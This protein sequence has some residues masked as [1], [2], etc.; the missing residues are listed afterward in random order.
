M[1]GTNDWNSTTYD[2]AHSFVYEYGG[3]LLSLLEPTP[4]DRILDLGCGTGHLTRQVADSGA[5][6]V[7]LDSARPMV[8]SAR[9]TYP[10]LSFVHGDARSLPFENAFDAVLSNA[11][12]HWISPLD[13]ALDAVAAALR[14]GGRFVAELGASGNVESIVTALESALQAAG[15]ESTNPWYFPTIG[16]GATRLER[17]G[18]EVRYARV[19]DRP[20]TLD[21]RDGLRNWIE[22]FADSFLA[23]VPVE[24]T[25]R[26]ISTVE[27][28]LRSTAFE[29]GDW[30]AD[31]RRLRFV[32]VVH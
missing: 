3:D 12:L 25:D 13:D 14:P 15:Y 4:A 11:V 9:E 20:T 18:F 8:E 5:S 7:G 6:V 29:D 1:T 2:D 27:R 24:T 10:E 16:E 19:L 31:Y 28:D 26:V 32:A 17:A 30:T 21:G 23:D 22:M